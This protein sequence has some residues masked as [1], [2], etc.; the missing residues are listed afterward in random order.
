MASKTLNSMQLSSSFCD[1]EWSSKISF[2]AAFSFIKFHFKEAQ[3][4]QF[5]SDI[6]MKTC[7]KW[8]HEDIVLAY[9]NFQQMKVNRDP[10]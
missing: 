6:I 8:M 9:Q 10:W 4:L 7:L 1:C 5:M 2:L 3:F